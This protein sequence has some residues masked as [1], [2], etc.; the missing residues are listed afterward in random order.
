MSSV[1]RATSQIGVRTKFLIA[2]NGTNIFEVMGTITAIMPESAFI[3]SVCPESI[4]SGSILRDLGKSVTTINAAGVHTQTF[5]LVQQQNGG[6]SEGV[7]VGISPFYVRVWA[8][9]PITNPVTVAR[10]G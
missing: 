5:C 9:D 2:L 8:A 4:S 10:L 1:T 3:S 6:G 7:D